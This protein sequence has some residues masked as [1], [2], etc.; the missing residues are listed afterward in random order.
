MPNGKAHQGPHQVYKQE[1]HRVGHAWRIGRARKGR[2]RTLP[3]SKS[4][5]ALRPR[6]AECLLLAPDVPDVLPD[7]VHEKDSAALCAK[8]ALHLH[9]QSLNVICYG[10][11]RRSQST[12]ELHPGVVVQRFLVLLWGDA[13]PRDLRVPLSLLLI[14]LLIK[15]LAPPEAGKG[16]DRSRCLDLLR[17]DLR[18]DGREVVAR[19]SLADWLPPCTSSLLS[20][21]FAG[22]SSLACPG[23]KSQIVQVSWLV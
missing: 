13:R 18:T 8:H 9:L 4:N 23:E 2:S 10:R 21:A 20:A 14:L 7:I 22:G 12:K 5:N 15:S 3:G 1:Q 19:G 17:L 16:L 6:C 11:R